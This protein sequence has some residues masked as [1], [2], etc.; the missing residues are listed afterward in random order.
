MKNIF[1]YIILINYILFSTFSCKID[2]AENVYDKQTLLGNVVY[3]KTHNNLMK[4]LYVFEFAQNANS[5]IKETDKK[6]KDSI[7]DLH[8]SGYKIRYSDGIFTMESDDYTIKSINTNG[9]LLSD[10]YANWTVTNYINNKESGI[11]DIKSTSTDNKWNIVV[12]DY[13]LYNSYKCDSEITIRLLGVNKQKYNLYSI[14]GNGKFI[15]IR[16]YNMNI[17]FETVISLK[18]VGHRIYHDTNG[19]YNDYGSNY[20]NNSHNETKNK[21]FNDGMMDM[22][23][24]DIYNNKLNT[25]SASMGYFGGNNIEVIIT[26]AYI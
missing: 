20:N 18:N 25:I 26:H 21:L 23:V 13:I 4:Y 22:S 5:Y 15:D 14:F 9:K 3:N 1:I 10:L 12:S 17:D 24:I 6:L 2:D 16:D 7:S 11:F 19:G 8:F